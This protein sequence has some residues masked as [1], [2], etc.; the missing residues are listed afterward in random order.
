M[1]VCL[2]DLLDQI[3]HVTHEGATMLDHTGCMAEMP[4]SDC[5]SCL[6]TA[7]Q[8]HQ[9]STNALMR[10]SLSRARLSCMA[11][12]S[13]CIPRKVRH[14]EGSS[15][16]CGATGTPKLLHN[17]NAHCRLELHSGLAGALKNR[18]LSRYC[19]WWRM[20][21]LYMTQARVSVNAEKIFGADRS[22]KGSAVSR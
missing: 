18:K 1:V 5:R 7:R 12:E 11:T 10:V 22:L 4:I 15:V 21:F 13:I 20:P 17:C 6:V 19:S 14:V 9:E 2:L 16:L 8:L 3:K